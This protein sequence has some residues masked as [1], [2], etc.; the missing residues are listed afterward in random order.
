MNEQRISAQRERAVGLN[1]KKGGVANPGGVD[2]QASAIPEPFRTR[3]KI[4]R[5]PENLPARNSSEI[6]E[7]ETT[8]SKK[9]FD[10]W[11]NYDD[12][13]IPTVLKQLMPGQVATIDVKAYPDGM[14]PPPSPS[15]DITVPQRDDSFRREA[16]SHRSQKRAAEAPAVQRNALPSQTQYYIDSFG[17]A[18]VRPPRR[19]SEPTPGN[20]PRLPLPPSP[21]MRSQDRHRSEKR[22]KKP[23]E[24]QD[25]QYAVFMDYSSEVD[26]TVVY[27]ANHGG[28]NV[29][30]VPTIKHNGERSPYN[31]RSPKEIRDW[32]TAT[33]NGER[34]ESGQRINQWDPVRPGSYL[35]RIEKSDVLLSGLKEN[36]VEKRERDIKRTPRVVIAQY[37]NDPDM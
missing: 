35:P 36:D 16:S 9:Y 7:G 17:S 20:P 34:L 30:K 37:F 13:P 27:V 18:V 15:E 21:Q 2:K 10:R 12:V 8:D 31:G 5:G 25:S 28:R 4:P 14:G 1:T 23:P 19:G 11:S 26:G 6:R 3:D 24:R 33:G 29:A 22:P 32:A